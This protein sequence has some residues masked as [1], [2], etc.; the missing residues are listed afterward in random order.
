MSSDSE[1]GGFNLPQ[2]LEERR[3]VLND[4]FITD[5]DKKNEDGDKI[6][7][8]TV[9]RSSGETRTYEANLSKLGQA[10]PSTTSNI[11]ILCIEAE[12]AAEGRIGTNPHLPSSAEVYEQAIE[13]IEAEGLTP[14]WEAVRE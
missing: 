10:A 14:A 5:F 13:R 12:L 7:E 8:I 2:L 4:D 3:A 1:G 9:K 11:D 6:K